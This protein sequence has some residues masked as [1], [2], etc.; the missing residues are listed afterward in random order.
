MAAQ[1]VGQMPQAVAAV[2]SVQSAQLAVE[3]LVAQAVLDMM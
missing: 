1:V 2:V 3:A